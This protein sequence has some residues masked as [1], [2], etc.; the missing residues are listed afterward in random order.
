MRMQPPPLSPRLL[1][2]SLLYLVHMSMYIWCDEDIFDSFCAYLQRSNH[3][4]YHLTVSTTVEGGDGKTGAYRSK[5]ETRSKPLLRSGW[6]VRTTNDNCTLWCSGLI[7]CDLGITPCRSVLCSRDSSRPWRYDKA[8]DLSSV[9][10]NE[11][12]GWFHAT[13][14]PESPCRSVAWQ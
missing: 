6:Q 9:G 8:A 1:S 5:A 4:Q 3:F 7:V 2:S 10:I 13:S 11:A 12:S 14:L